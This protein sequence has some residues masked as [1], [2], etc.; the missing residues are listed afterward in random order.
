[1]ACALDVS[2]APSVGL[3]ID[4]IALSADDGIYTVTEIERV[5]LVLVYA[6][7][8]GCVVVDGHIPRRGATRQQCAY[9]QAN[10]KAQG[11]KHHL[12]CSSHYAFIFIESLERVITLPVLIRVVVIHLHHVSFIFYCYLFA[13]EQSGAIKG[14]ASNQGDRSHDSLNRA[15]MDLSP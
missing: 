1:V 11:E 14:A 10:G 2:D 3:L 15:I 9:Q 5:A 13:V 6:Q 12:K 4:G 8:I 7:R